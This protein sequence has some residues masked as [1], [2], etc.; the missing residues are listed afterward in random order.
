LQAARRDRAYDRQRAIPPRPSTM[1]AIV[2]LARLE[3]RSERRRA[4][5]DL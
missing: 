3:T 2:L 5:L 1:S 4:P